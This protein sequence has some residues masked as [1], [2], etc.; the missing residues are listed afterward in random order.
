MYILKVRGI[1]VPALFSW[2]KVK[3]ELVTAVIVCLF[4]GWLGSGLSQGAGAVWVVPIHGTVEWGMSGFVRRAVRDAEAQRAAVIL[5]EINTFGGR[6]DAATEIRDTLLS[7]RVPV[8][9]MVTE[10]AWSAGALIAL[11]AQH[12]AMAPGASIGAA[13]PQPAEEKIISAV[14]G[15]FEAT[16]QRWGRDV[17]IAA[18][19]VDRDVDIPGI[20]PAG[21]ILT[22]TAERAKELGFIDLVAS[23]SEEVLQ[24]LGYS[25]REMVRLTPTAAEMAVGFLTQPLVSSLLLVLGF[26]GLV[27]EVLT[28]GFGIPGIVGGLSLLLFFGGRLLTGLAGWE[29]IILFAAGLILLAVEAFL[30]PGF[31]IAGLAGLAAIFA[32]IV[33]SYSSSTAGLISLNAALGVTILVAALAWRYIRKTSTWRRLILSTSLRRED[34]DD[35]SG[36]QGLV[37]KAGR[38]LT[39]LRPAG[40]VEI[41]G[42][43][44]DVVTEGGFVAR[45][46]TVEVISVQ[47]NRVVVRPIRID[48]NT[49]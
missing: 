45:G 1:L 14:R 7:S 15:E 26:T 43:R 11:A 21:K 6:L 13:E 42:K 5:L 9:A 24:Q 16:A 31:G 30:I 40:I 49:V 19:M 27:L 17:E 36:R 35:D 41:D 32:S 38:A 47:G 25:S 29:V 48:E 23:S 2:I 34:A 44:V 3:R 12:L 39:P 18:A 4:I 20:S 33:L 10:R 28:P 22:L 37:G 46:T 8:A